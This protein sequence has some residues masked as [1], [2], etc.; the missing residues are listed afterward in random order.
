MHTKNLSMKQ[1]VIVA[2]VSILTSYVSL[3]QGPPIFTDS[4]V[5][6]G[7]EGRGI[8]T[9][10]KYISKQNINVY[11]QPVGVPYNITSKLLAGIIAPF[12]S[13]SPKGMKTQSGIGDIAVFAKYTIIQKDDL[14]K[15][16]R[17]LA[18]VKE[19]FPTG[20]TTKT[21]GIGSGAYQ[22]AIGLVSGYITKK[23][24]IYGEIGYNITS[25]KLPDNFIYNIAFGYPIVPPQYPPRQLNVYLEFNGNYVV[26][27]KQNNLFISPGIQLIPSKRFLFETGI[28]FALIEDVPNNQKTNFMYLLGTRILIF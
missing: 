19:T 6:L 27:N 10:G 9:F 5:L 24:G 23:Y 12:I 13:K 1:F 15:T 22:T 4:P 8:R 16:F 17:T 21:P 20:N 25:N 7:L 11:M 28:Q 18:K 26:D 3:A 14:G 2:S